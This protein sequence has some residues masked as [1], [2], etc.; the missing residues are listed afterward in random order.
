MIDSRGETKVITCSNKECQRR[1]NVHVSAAHTVF[2][3]PNLDQ[4]GVAALGSGAATLT[5]GAA[6]EAAKRVLIARAMPDPF[7]AAKYF[8]SVTQSWVAPT[9][10]PKLLQTIVDHG[11]QLRG[12][13]ED[14][15]PINL[16]ARILGDQL[17]EVPRTDVRTFLK[18]AK[19][20]GAF[21]FA[22][23]LPSTFYAAYV[24]DVTS[25]RLVRAF[26]RSVIRRIWQIRPWE[27]GEAA[28]LAKLVLGP[29]FP[30]GE[31][32]FRQAIEEYRSRTVTAEPR[33]S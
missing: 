8:L 23:G 26:T 11:E 31:S 12:T 20:G 4:Y 19:A 25:D 5:T 3:R 33:V 7:A 9:Q 16:Q 32:V 1:F 2:A 29:A 22:P 15:T 18:M 6:E 17:C 14:R 21:E 30:G 13:G 28:G 27:V 24:N 10:L